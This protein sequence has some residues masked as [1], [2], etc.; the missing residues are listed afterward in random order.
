M[1]ERMH[2]IEVDLTI[3]E[4]ST[5]RAPTAQQLITELDV[6]LGRMPSNPAEWATRTEIVADVSR[7]LAKMDLD[8]ENLVRYG[9]PERAILPILLS[10]I[11]YGK[12][13]ALPQVDRWRELLRLPQTVAEGD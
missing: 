11:S 10:V 4:L 7:G 5:E 12:T 2:T 3:S 8:A 1:H 13:P 9:M 6:A